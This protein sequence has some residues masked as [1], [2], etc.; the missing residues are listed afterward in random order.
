MFKLFFLKN[1]S[2]MRRA[3]RTGATPAYHSMGA[4]FPAA[5][6]LL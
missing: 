1:S 3:E 4:K 5:G 2:I 6:P